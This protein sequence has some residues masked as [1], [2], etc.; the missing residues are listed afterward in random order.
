MS[1]FSKVATYCIKRMAV[2]RRTI[3]SK[4][5]K[6][7]ILQNPCQKV[8][9]VESA[10]EKITGIDFRPAALLKRSFHQVGFPLYTSQFQRFF[11]QVNV[12]FIF[13]KVTCFALQGRNFIKTLLHHKLFQIVLFKTFSE[14]NLW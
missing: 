9:V 14:K 3:F 5:F 6:R 4:I 13:G 12:S 7:G 8:S 11:S 2:L 10:F 1:N